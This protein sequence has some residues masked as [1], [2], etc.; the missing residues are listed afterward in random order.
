MMT[1]TFDPLWLYLAVALLIS[2]GGLAIYW[3]I[4][5]NRYQQGM[6]NLQQ[7]LTERQQVLAQVQQ[8]VALLTQEKHQ[9]E[10][11]AVQFRTQAE[12]YAERI[13]EKLTELD[14]LQQ[15][16]VLAE[17]NENEL[18]RYINALKERVGA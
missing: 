18:E 1:L 12:S 13:S 17:D 7:D 15:R 10:Q 6:E 14:R 9:A 2:L 16:L 3:F 8:S 5:Q 4:E 11:S